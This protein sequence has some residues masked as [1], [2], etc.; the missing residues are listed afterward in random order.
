VAQGV[1]A[2]ESVLSQAYEHWGA[3]PDAIYAYNDT[4][5]IGVMAVLRRQGLR[6]PGDV[7]LTGFDDIDVAAF[8]EPPLTTLRQP[9]H[10]MGV[11]A[12]QLLLALAN[13]ELSLD[14]PQQVVLEGE[15]IVRSST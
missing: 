1:V 8:L 13:H 11:K 4:M 2:G 12:M 14:Q 6:I 3:P 10:R 15:L 5:A 7:A 9:R